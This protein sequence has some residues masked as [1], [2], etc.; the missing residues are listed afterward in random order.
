M[1]RI[2]LKIF[3]ALWAFF[4]PLGLALRD[5]Q[6][7]INYSVF[8]RVLCEFSA[9]LRFLSP[10]W[11]LPS[12]NPELISNKKLTV[13]MLKLKIGACNLEKVIIFIII[14][15]I[16]M[17]MRTVFADDNGNEM[18]VYINDKEQLFLS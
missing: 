11:F 14:I 1:P 4:G 6:L 17:S 5:S 7:F 2:T 3:W 13:Q 8:F 12:R 9:S 10:L 16:T 18:D 15:Q